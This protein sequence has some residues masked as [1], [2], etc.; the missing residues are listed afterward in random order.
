ME[1]C[2]YISVNRSSHAPEFALQMS[3]SVWNGKSIVL[4]RVSWGFF[5]EIAK[6]DVGR[7][8]QVIHCGVAAVSEG[9][10][11]KYVGVCEGNTGGVTSILRRCKT[12]EGY[13]HMAKLLV[14]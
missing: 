8:G 14:C 3:T 11:A 13:I 4:N 10:G 12:Q 9:G 6:L 2:A 5:V 1:M 7:K